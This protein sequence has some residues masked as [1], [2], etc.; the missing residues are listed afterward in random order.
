MIVLLPQP[1]ITP[2]P[3]PAIVKNVRCIRNFCYVQCNAFILLLSHFVTD[4]HRMI[5]HLFDCWFERLVQ[6]QSDKYFDCV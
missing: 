2:V 5:L 6:S 1:H 4:C 3:L